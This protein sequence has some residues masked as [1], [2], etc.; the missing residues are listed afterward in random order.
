MS[1]NVNGGATISTSATIDTTLT[2]SFT[3]Q[4]GSVYYVTGSIIYNSAGGCCTPTITSITA[5]GGNTIDVYFT[6][7]SG[8]DACSYTT[9]QS[10]TDNVNWGGNNTGGCTSPR[11]ITAPTSSTY[12]RMLVGCASTT[13]SYS[14][15]V[16]FTT[17]SSYDY[18]N[19]DYY[20]CL[21]C[22]AGPVGTILVGFAA[23]SSVTLNRFYIPVGGPD[24]FAYKVTATDSPGTAYLL[25]TTYGSF[26]TCALACAV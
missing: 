12:Y 1:L 24:G 21:D 15:S 3:A 13:S 16:L 19:A 18:Y 26:T 6:T 11:N 17:S 9:I 4:T 14:D 5:S 20:D 7:G 22:G 23:G 10:S 8:C 2:A 25:T